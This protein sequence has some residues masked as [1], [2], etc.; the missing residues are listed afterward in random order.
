VAWRGRRCNGPS[1]WGLQAFPAENLLCA[2][3]PLILLTF[4][5]LTGSFGEIL[6]GKS[7]WGLSCLR[8]VSVTNTSNELMRQWLLRWLRLTGLTPSTKSK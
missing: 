8:R 1:R 4:Y 3:D 2:L 6:G 5:P 7:A